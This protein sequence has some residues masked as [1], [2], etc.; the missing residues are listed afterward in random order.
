M[1][2]K[3]RMAMFVLSCDKY[4]P[5]WNDFFNLKDRFWGDCKYPWYVVTESMDYERA[6][7][8]VIKCGKGLDL[9]GRL[10]KAALSVD[11][12]YISIFLEDYFIDSKVDN[13]VVDSL[14][15]LMDEKKITTINVSEVFKWIINQRNKQYLREH[16]IIVPPH[17]RYGISTEA[18]IWRKDFLLEI[19]GDEDCSAWKFE[20][21]RSREAAS[22][23]GLRGFN[24]VDDRMPYHVSRIPVIVHGGFYPRAIRHFRK[25]GYNI[26]TSVFPTMTWKQ[27]I[28]YDL[29]H[30][31]AK[32]PFGHKY[33]KWI[34]R[35]VFG[36]KFGSDTL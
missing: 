17:L 31:S 7:V 26:N 19:L 33:L 21:D 15:Q 14:L 10:K 27:V 36:M 32:I 9:A 30:Y 4:S 13:G 6:G 1:K 8:T 2:E 16:L 29:K 18:T 11:A 25:L 22:P 34:G 20:V 5:V 35:N 24:L 23:N 28:L 12:E 3:I